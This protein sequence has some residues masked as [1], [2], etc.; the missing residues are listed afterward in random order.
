M[1]APTIDAQAAER[2]A[3]DAPVPDI[4]ARA[5]AHAEAHTGDTRTLVADAIGAALGHTRPIDVDFYVTPCVIDGEEEPHPAY[6]AVMAHLAVA[7]IQSVWRWSA[8]RTP[9]EIADVLR[10]AGAR[11]EV[12][13]LS[14]GAPWGQPHRAGCEFQTVAR[15]V[16]S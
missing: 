5:A 15:A 10:A 1:N 4:L 7:S 13:C 14:C 8:L 2:L 11:T 12:T 3:Y 6:R 16:A 9:G